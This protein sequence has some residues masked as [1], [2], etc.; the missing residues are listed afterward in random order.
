MILPENLTPVHS[1]NL[2]LQLFGFLYFPVPFRE[3]EFSNSLTDQISLFSVNLDRPVTL[4]I[5]E[6]LYGLDRVSSHSSIRLNSEPPRTEVL[7]LHLCR[8]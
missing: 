4:I 2:R 8:W 6:T 7:L 3:M 1:Y 5:I